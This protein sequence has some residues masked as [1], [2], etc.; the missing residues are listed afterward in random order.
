MDLI[1]GLPGEN[2]DMFLETLAWSRA[3]APESLTVHTLCIKRSSLLHLWEAELPDG[4]M[5][6]RMVDAGRQEAEKRGMQP[7]YLYRQ[8]H[9]AGN[10]E[11]VGYALPGHA[12]V[13]NVDMME[14]TGHVLAVGAGAISK[15]VDPRIGRIE[16]APN[17]S[18]ITQ[19]IDRVDEMAERKRRLWAE[20]WG[21][22]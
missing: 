4:D 22:S 19:Y 10:L 13:Y 21:V 3:M 6:S 9:M 8:K 7:Y 14:E 17:V 2:L 5:V 18:E 12:C 1:A 16:R 15:R 20:E 11:N